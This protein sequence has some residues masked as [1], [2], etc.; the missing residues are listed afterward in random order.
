VSIQ[1]EL[2]NL[3]PSEKQVGRMVAYSFIRDAINTLP[4]P[5]KWL[6]AIAVIAAT[7]YFNKT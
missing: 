5:V 1:D 3:T 4:K 2:K 7:V 6:G